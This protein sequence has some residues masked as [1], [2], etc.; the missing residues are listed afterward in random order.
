MSGTESCDPAPAGEGQSD[1]PSAVVCIDKK[2]H[3]I[4]G[5]PLIERLAISYCAP[6]VFLYWS[7]A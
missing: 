4:H 3:V 2:K 7:R 1:A 6:I 5:F